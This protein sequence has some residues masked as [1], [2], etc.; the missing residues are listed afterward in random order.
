MLE[1]DFRLRISVDFVTSHGGHAHSRVCFILDT[2]KSGSG[3]Q[4]LLRRVLCLPFPQLLVLATVSLDVA[5]QP[6][7]TLSR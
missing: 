2:N 6:I 4:I 1:G 5:S 3:T 7:H